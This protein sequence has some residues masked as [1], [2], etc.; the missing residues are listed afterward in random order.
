MP[1][2]RDFRVV[3]VGGESKQ[4]RYTGQEVRV[5]VKGEGAGS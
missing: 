2:E 4:V 1:G 5:K 3:V